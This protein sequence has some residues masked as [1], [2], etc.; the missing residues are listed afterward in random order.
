MKKC[1]RCPKEFESYDSLKRH[2]G[3]IHKVDAVTF[4]VE[5]HLNGCWPKCKCGCGGNVK[6]SYELKGFRK[7]CQGHQSRVHNNWGHNKAALEKSVE[8]RKERFASGEISVWNK[9]LTI[10]D[11]RVKN[12]IDKST[13]AINSNSKEIKR[14]SD[15]MTRQRKDGTI[16][17]L[18]GS[19]HSQW[20]GGVSEIN[21]LARARS[22][23]YKEWKYPILCRDGFKCT[24]CG[25]TKGLQVHHDRDRMCEIIERHM[26]DGIEPKTFEEKEFIADAVVDYHVKNKV[27]GK[28]LCGKCHGKIHPSLNF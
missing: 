11:E 16:P 23:L 28:T 21:V 7:F 17:D 18:K 2:V 14:R 26:V 4:Y 9:G 10:N 1:N 5:C 3:L 20:K 15:L 19:S 8:T 25:D 22:R 6:W 24:E 13:S 12:N 27:S